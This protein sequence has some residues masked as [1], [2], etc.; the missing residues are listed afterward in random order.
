MTVENELLVAPQ[1]F[2]SFHVIGDV[3]GFLFFFVFAAITIDRYHRVYVS[4]RGFFLKNALSINQKFIGPKL[5]P[6]S[7]GV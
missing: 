7:S 5:V 3:D 4:V 2:L 1:R 6:S